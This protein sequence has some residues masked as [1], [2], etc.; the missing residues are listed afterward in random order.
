MIKNID[1]Y[2]FLW[3]CQADLQQ[4]LK[5]GT[6]LSSHKCVLQFHPVLLH[7]MFNSDHAWVKANKS[8][9]P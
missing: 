1:S 8:E 3:Q 6:F 9:N 5:T 7:L 4:Y 2:L